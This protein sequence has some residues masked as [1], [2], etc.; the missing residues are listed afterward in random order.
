MRR[1]NELNEKDFFEQ[2]KLRE[3]LSS[4]ERSSSSES[5]SLRYCSIDMYALVIESIHDVPAK[6]YN[7]ARNGRLTTPENGDNR[8][9]SV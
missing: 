6:V 4:R 3:E 1:A 7:S 8:K 9:C 2:Q 5:Q